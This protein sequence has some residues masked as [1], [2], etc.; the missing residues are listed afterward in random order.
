MRVLRIDGA[1]VR[2]YDETQSLRVAVNLGNRQ[3]KAPS[4]VDEKDPRA[5]RGY[6]EPLV[7][8]FGVSVIVMD[9][10]ASYRIVLDKQEL[11]HQLCQFTLRR[12]VG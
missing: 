7:Q 2:G 1:Y 10:L 6:L 5:V 11:E 3:P 8:R 9:D 12:W 4:Y